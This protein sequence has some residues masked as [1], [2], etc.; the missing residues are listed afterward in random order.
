MALMDEF[1]EE[2]KAVLQNGTTKQKI[3]YIWDYYKW[4]I[5]IPVIIVIAGIS[6]IVNIITAP[7]I[8]LNGVMMNIYKMESDFSGEELVNGFYDAHEIDSKEEEIN[9]NMNLYFNSDSANDNYQTLQVLMAWHSADSLDFITSDLSAMTD[10]TYRGY[11]S[12]LREVL[13]AD[14]LAMYEPYFLYID[15][16][17]FI[18]RSEKIDEMEDVSDMTYPDPTKP[19]D[20]VDPIPVMIDISK[21]KK[22]ADAYAGTKDIIAF[23]I[24][25]NVQNTKTTLNFLDYLME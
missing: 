20:M 13:N 22:T 8:I 24:T 21:S 1:K 15:Q 3:S 7:D 4:H 2:R 11:F 6:W 5:L 10:L 18:K 14:Q 16:D 12:D 25:A 23:G 19:E 17:F 9:L